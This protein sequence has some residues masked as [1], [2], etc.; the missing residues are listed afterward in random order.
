MPNPKSMI[1]LMR[2]M[3]RLN[4]ELKLGWGSYLR[5]SGVVRAGAGQAELAAE[6]GASYGQARGLAGRTFAIPTKTAP[7]GRARTISE[8]RPDIQ[9]F[10]KHIRSTSNPWFLAAIGTGRARGHKSVNQAAKDMATLL[11]EEGLFELENL[12]VSKKLLS[13]INQPQNPLGIKLYESIGKGAPKNLNMAQ[14]INTD[15]RGSMHYPIKGKSTIKSKTTFD[16]ITAGERTMTTRRV[17]LGWENR[18]VGEIFPIKGKGNQTQ[19]IEI[20]HKPV[21]H[22]VT[23]KESQAFLNRWS[24]LEGHGPEQ[25]H[26]FFKRGQKITMVKFKPVLSPVTTTSIT[27]KRKLKVISGFQI[28]ADQIGLRVAKAA[29]IPTGGTA[30]PRFMTTHG[31]NPKLAAKYGVIEGAADPRIYPKRTLANV[32]NADGTLI[33]ANNWSSAGTKLTQRYIKQEGKPSL[34][35]TQIKSPQDVID[36]IIKNDIYTINIAGNRLPKPGKIGVDEKH[37]AWMHILNAFKQLTQ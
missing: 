24:Q 17:G 27:P 14:K 10:G 11:G 20:T 3:F 5:G 25:F 7:H 9:S 22:T 31:P 30:P 32:Q 23:G 21:I 29:K 12:A 18:K 15:F 33:V 34:L 36:W 35:S 8:I 16:A 6:L 19:L 13:S 2:M 37:P 4:P 26:Q 28:G 1:E